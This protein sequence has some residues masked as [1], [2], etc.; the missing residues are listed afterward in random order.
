MTPYTLLHHRRYLPLY[1]VM[2]AIFVFVGGY[3]E[4][5]AGMEKDRRLSL[6]RENQM[7]RACQNLP[8]KKGRGDFYSEIFQADDGASYA[9]LLEE[10]GLTVKE[11]SEEES[12]NDSL[13]KFNKITLEGTGTFPQIIRGFDI[14]QSKERWTAADLLTLSRRGEALD[15]T[16]EITAFQSRGTYEEEKY[17][18]HRSHGDR[19]EPGR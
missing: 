2:A 8:P 3:M 15:F 5:G 16:M 19:K 4:I 17:R 11:I 18:T 10:A 1:G 14:I 12:R 9:A 13:G 7:L 6:E